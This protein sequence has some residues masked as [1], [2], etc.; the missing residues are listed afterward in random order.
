MTACLTCSLV[1]HPFLNA[2]TQQLTGITQTQYALAA[3]AEN[4]ISWPLPGLRKVCTG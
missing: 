3:R 4:Q 2:F 1:Q